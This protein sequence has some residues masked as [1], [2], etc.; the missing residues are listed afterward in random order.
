MNIISLLPSFVSAVQNLHNLLLPVCLVLAFAGLIYKI[1]SL[2]RERSVTSL[3][4][5]LVKMLVAFVL[6]GLMAT[7]GDS[8]TGMVTDLDNQL[9]LNQGNVL[10]DYVQAVATKFGVNV[11][12]TGTAATTQ[13]PQ[14][15]QNNPVNGFLNWAGQA[16]SN[17]GKLFQAVALGAD[18]FAAA[19][20][21]IFVLICS[22]LGM[23]AM[24]LVSGVQQILVLVCIGLSPIFLGCLLI[25]PLGQL[26]AR[27][28]TNYVALCLWPLGW[29]IANLVTKALIDLA[30]NPSNNTGL[31][32]FNFLGGG[33]VW[34]LGLGL[35]ALFSS[36]AAPWLVTK[37]LSA[38][39]N[40]MI[41]L[42]G[43]AMG[44][45]VMVT[46]TAMSAAS[47][48]GASSTGGASV[49][50]GTLAASTLGPMRSYASR[51]TSNGSSAKT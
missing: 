2:F 39:E 36:I 45:A 41:A 16:A 9:G 33:Y 4:P 19:M 13:N 29:G 7:W 31:G 37:A 35:W 26:A 3:F 42:F 6:L 44:S 34:W 10:N 32:A 17:V 48:A 25:P 51:P 5:Y 15:Q 11:N 49:G 30:V 50:A 14:D 21:G 12:N 22:M 23:L 18:G 38:G 24:W 43:G 8:L 20:M 47:V 27:F 28:F 1:T 40:P 46:Q